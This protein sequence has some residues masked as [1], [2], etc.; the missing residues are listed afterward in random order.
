MMELVVVDPNT[1]LAAKDVYFGTA[2][3]ALNMCFI[4]L[5]C[6]LELLIVS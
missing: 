5:V 6:R 4:K 1:K 2:A 3:D